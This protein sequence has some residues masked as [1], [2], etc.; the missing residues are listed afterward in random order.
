MWRW[1]MGVMVKG[2]W[3]TWWLRGL[4]DG[5]CGHYMYF[6]VDKQGK[7]VIMIKGEGY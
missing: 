4:V 2:Y 5:I 3:G 7:I 6:F 1:D